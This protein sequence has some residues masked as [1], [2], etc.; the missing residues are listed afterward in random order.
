V[1][2]IGD[3]SGFNA[4]GVVVDPKASQQ[5]R[6]LMQQY[7][8]QYPDMPLRDIETLARSTLQTGD[9]LPSVSIGKPGDKFYKLV[10]TAE[11]RGP[12]PGTVYWMDGSQLD[13]V[14]RVQ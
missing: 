9:T 4:L 7:R 11:S 3:T 5:G 14:M 1:S 12:S 6:L 8:Q 13:T 10:P 2:L